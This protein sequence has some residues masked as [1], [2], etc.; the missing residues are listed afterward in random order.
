[1]ILNNLCFHD[2]SP[3][4]HLGLGRQEHG[5]TIDDDTGV[6]LMESP[7]LQDTITDHS[8]QLL[9]QKYW[10][11]TTQTVCSLGFL[12]QERQEGGFP[13]DNDT[14]V[15]LMESPDIQDN[16]AGHFEQLLLKKYCRE[17]ALT[18]CSPRISPSGTWGSSTTSMGLGPVSTPSGWTSAM[19]WA[20]G[21]G[22]RSLASMIL[23]QWSFEVG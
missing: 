3:K 13:I 7:H 11:K 6:I 8:D 20:L 22:S 1:M 9:L 2:L 5:V 19:S 18:A 21:F 4:W 16:I 23:T 12:R 10:R 14:G 17:T 15:I